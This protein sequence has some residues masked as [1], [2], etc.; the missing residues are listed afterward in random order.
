MAQITYFIYDAVYIHIRKE[1]RGV[2]S[3]WFIV[4]EALVIQDKDIS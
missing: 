2:Q 3:E 4:A 1:R